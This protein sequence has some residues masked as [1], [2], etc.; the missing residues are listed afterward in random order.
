[1]LI[2]CINIANP[3]CVVFK[4][5][6]STQISFTFLRRLYSSEYNPYSKKACSSHFNFFFQR[7]GIDKTDPNELTAEEITKF[8]RLDIDPDT[9]TFQRGDSLDILLGMKTLQLSCRMSWVLF[10]F[11]CYRKF[12]FVVIKVF[13]SNAPSAYV[14]LGEI[15]FDIKETTQMRWLISKNKFSYLVHILFL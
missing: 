13:K 2:S 1:M 3:L 5:W 15:W 8:A 4:K 10:L 14:D 11:T 7:L 12:K 6:S 9:I